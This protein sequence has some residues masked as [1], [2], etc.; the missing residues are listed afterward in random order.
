[1]RTKYIVGA[2]ALVLVHSAAAGKLCSKVTD[3][4]AVEQYKTIMT[5]IEVL[6]TLST[7][8]KVE[9]QVYGKRT[10]K[11]FDMDGKIANYQFETSVWD[12]ICPSKEEKIRVMATIND[13]KM[14][15][16]TRLV[17]KANDNINFINLYEKP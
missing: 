1:M 13:W 12:T 16:H 10:S 15:N 11:C 17:E 14:K 4:Q 2:V 5:N 8:C 7:D 3:D 9:L 6:A